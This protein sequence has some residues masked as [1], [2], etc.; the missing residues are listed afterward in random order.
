MYYGARGLNHEMNEKRFRLVF[1][2]LVHDT[3]KKKLVVFFKYRLGFPDNFIKALLT[4]PPR[5]IAGDLGE[6]DAKT[7]R[8]NLEDCGCRIILEP[9]MTSVSKPFCITKRHYRIIKKEF[10]K[11]LRVC[12]CQAFMLARIDGQEGQE[13]IYPSMMGDIEEKLAGYF[14]ESDTVL[15]IDDNR[16]VILGFATNNDGTHRLQDKAIRLLK[17]LIGETVSVSCGA[18]LFPREGQSLVDLL[19]LAD[20]RRIQNN[21]AEDKSIHLQTVPLSDTPNRSS[22]EEAG[23]DKDPIQQC[24]TKAYGKIFRR[25]CTMDKPTFCAGLCQ[26]PQPRQK[27][28]LDRLPYDSPLVSDL[29]ALIEHQTETVISDEIRKRYQAILYQIEMER[30]LENRAAI[31]KKVQVVLSNTEALPTLPPIAAQVFQIASNEQSSA[32]DLANVIMLDQ[33]LTSKLLKIVNSAFYGF[34]QKIG[35]VKQA[36]VILGLDDIVNLAI[37]LSAT[38]VF[39]V[40]SPCQFFD[41][42]N[43]WHHSIGTAIIARTLCNNLPAYQQQ[44]IFTAGLLHDLG[45]IIFLEQFPELY[46]SLNSKIKKHG[47]L[48]FELEEEMFG[49]NHASIGKLI[50]KNWNMPDYLVEAIAYH[51]QPSLAARHQLTAAIVGLADYLY[52]QVVKTDEIADGYSRLTVSHLKILQ[53]MFAHLDQHNIDELVSETEKILRDNQNAFDILM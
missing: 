40:Q 38:R 33:S 36:I 46:Q 37:G 35:T 39:N 31:Q 4:S 32:D 50:S 41:P 22:S 16:I 45:R 24:F 8:D 51:H 2:G 9:L 43:L 7:L 29:E 30:E 23:I 21:G 20:S 44:G 12:S 26:I 11:T 15:G 48:I 13:T 25:L 19:Q 28:F 14:R 18:A 10:S 5:I 53:S 49:L 17:E 42:K 52:H 6:E 27:E 34:R 1:N 3:K 47:L